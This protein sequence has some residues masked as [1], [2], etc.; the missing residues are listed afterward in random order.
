MYLRLHKLLGNFML[1]VFALVI[2]G[3]TSK[4]SFAKDNGHAIKELGAKVEFV[5]IYQADVE[6]EDEEDSEDEEEERF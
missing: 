6:E 2:M 4:A 3:M 5:K 1:L